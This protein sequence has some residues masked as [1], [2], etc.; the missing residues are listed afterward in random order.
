[1]EYRTAAIN[2]FAEMVVNLNRDTFDIATN[3]Q[4]VVLMDEFVSIWRGS[5]AEYNTK[6]QRSTEQNT[7]NH[8]EK[9][10]NTAKYRK[11]E[12]LLC[13]TIKFLNK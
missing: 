2:G 11:E 8:S 12:A 13:C 6:E 3:Q 1:M 4:L 5:F 9:I 10:E 7:M